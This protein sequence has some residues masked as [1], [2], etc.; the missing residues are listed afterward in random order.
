MKTLRMASTPILLSNGARARDTVIDHTVS[1]PAAREISAGW[2]GHLKADRSAGSPPQAR[3]IDKAQ[4]GMITLRNGRVRT[5]SAPNCPNAEVA[6]VVVV[7]ESKPGF[8]GTDS[9]TLEVQVEG[10]TPSRH[11]FNVTVAGM[12]Q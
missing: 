6:A 2:F 9:F 10:G 1:G 5:N 4:N 11:K 12:L 8:I 3:V 7:Y